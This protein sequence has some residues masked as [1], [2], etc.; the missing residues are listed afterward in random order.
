MPASNTVDAVRGAVAAFNE[1][2][3]TALGR[4]LGRSFFTHR[5]ALEERGAN[6]VVGSLIADV[7]GGF[8][9][10]S[11]ELDNLEADGDGARGRATVRGTCSG[12]L[13]G[14]APTGRTIEWPVAF[15]VRPAEGGLA[16]NL[17]D[18]TVP[19]LMDLFRQ[20]EQVNPAD[21]MHLPPRHATSLLPE[22]LFRLAFN[23]QV[24][25]MPCDH[26]GG[27]RVTRS[28]VTRCG[29]CGPDDIWPALRLC[30]TCGHVGCCDTSA[31]KHARGHFE[32][33]GHPLIR[34]LRTAETWGWCYVDGV[35]VGGDTVDRS[36]PRAPA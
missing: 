26:L 24:A 33:T 3:R 36:A 9:D 17:D 4:A 19:V 13:W 7:A 32:A 31:N 6:D 22:F 34:S 2:D 21:R 20:L 29:Q 28:D 25:D 12:S 16:F 35:L 5:P 30:L 27:V 11:I 15:R 18:L 10:L 23:G 1:G 14:V 8:P